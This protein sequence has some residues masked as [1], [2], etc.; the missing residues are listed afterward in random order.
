MGLGMSYQDITS[1]LKEMDDFD[2]S[3]GTLNAVTDKL[4]PV[5]AEWHSRPLEAIYLVL[6]MDGIYFKSRENGRVITKVIYNILGINQEGYKEILGFYVAESEG[7]NFWWVFS[8]ILNNGGVF[9][10]F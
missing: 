8:M 4:I 5:I 3:P 1:H 10:M 7:A 6:F 2:I 9:R